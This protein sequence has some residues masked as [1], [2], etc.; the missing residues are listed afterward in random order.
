MGNIAERLRLQRG[1]ARFQR[2]PFERSAAAAARSPPPMPP[3]PPATFPPSKPLSHHHP[4]NA[5]HINTPSN[6]NATALATL[7]V[8]FARM[9]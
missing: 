3:P 5:P 4:K 8:R 6:T 1:S 7:L 2:A 9:Q